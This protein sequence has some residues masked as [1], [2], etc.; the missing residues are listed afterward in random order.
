MLRGQCDP[1]GGLAGDPAGAG[2]HPFR[3]GRDAGQLGPQHRQHAFSDRTAN[4]PIPGPLLLAASV[5]HHS[6][7][8]C[9]PSLQG[10]L[11]RAGEPRPVPGQIHGLHAPDR[12]GPVHFPLRGRLA[13]DPGQSIAT[14]P[15]PGTPPLRPAG[16]VPGLHP[17]LGHRVLPQ[18]PAPGSA[19]SVNPLCGL[20]DLCER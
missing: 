15:A 18:L 12:H 14:G 10:I 9:Q 16:P 4:V 20:C 1:G 19:Q 3:L 17:R 7:Q 6:G 11:A 5:R 13:F 8:V 2:G